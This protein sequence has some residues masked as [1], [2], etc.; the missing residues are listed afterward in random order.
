MRIKWSL[1]EAVVLLEYFF[2][3]RGEYKDS[4]LQT[5]RNM[6]I[7][8]ALEMNIAYDE[9]FRNITG[10]RMQLGCIEYVVTDGK[11]GLQNAARIFNDAYDLFQE[12]RPKYYL[13]LS[14]FYKKYQQDI[15][16]ENNE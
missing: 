8:R 16:G 14:E 10:L 12:N 11:S 4:E 15:G 5:I 1:E 3:S 6:M 13:I 2:V 9:K 7:K